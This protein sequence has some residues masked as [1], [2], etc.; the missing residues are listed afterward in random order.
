[1]LKD[2]AKETNFAL[3]NDEEQDWDVWWIDGPILPTL[4]HKMKW[5]Q[6]TNHLPAVQYLAR[7]NLLAR[8][9]NMMQK[10]MP[11]YYDFFP[12]TWILPS[13]SKS[14]KE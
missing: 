5:Y 12:Q 9:L 10:A 11:E 7:K 3:S 1:M 14:F 8:N 4:I 13:D 6:R 2:A